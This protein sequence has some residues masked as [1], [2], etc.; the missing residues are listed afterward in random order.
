LIKIEKNNEIYSRFYISKV[1]FMQMSS[2]QYDVDTFNSQ[3][4]KQ[5]RGNNENE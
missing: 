2:A 4:A 3:K 1:E 5:K